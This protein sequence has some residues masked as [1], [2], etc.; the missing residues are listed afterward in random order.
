[1]K[2]TIA[3]AP[4]HYDFLLSRTPVQLAAYAVLKNGVVILSR[5]GGVK[6]R[7]IRILCEVSQAENLLH[8]AE[9]ICPEA[10]A[11]IKEALGQP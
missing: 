3:L 9:P 11:Q 5:E 1:M 7:M 6:H 8:L 4:E 2:I 10:A